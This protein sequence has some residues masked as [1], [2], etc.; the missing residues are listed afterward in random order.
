MKK[1]KL[2][3]FKSFEL[4]GKQLKNLLGGSGNDLGD[5][6]KDVVVELLDA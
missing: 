4:A 3:N 1:S 5:A 2:S 6:R